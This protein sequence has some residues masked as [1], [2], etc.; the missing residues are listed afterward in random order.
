LHRAAKFGAE[1]AAPLDQRDALGPRQL[2]AREP[3]HAV[4]DAADAVGVGAHDLGQAHILGVSPGL[5]SSCAAWLIAPTGLR[6]SWAML[7]LRRPS[8]ASLDCCTL[9]ASQAGVLEK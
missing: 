9:E 8:A 7:A 4:D 5:A 2:A 3:Q 1:L 6:I